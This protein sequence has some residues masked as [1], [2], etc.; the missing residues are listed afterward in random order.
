MKKKTLPSNDDVLMATRV[1]MEACHNRAWNAG[2]WHDPATGEEKERNMGELLAL[3][4]SELSEALEGHRKGLMDDKLTDRRMVPVEL[5]DAVIRIFDAVG[6]YYPEDYPA[7]LEKL[8][9]NDTRE[10]HK[11]ENRVK[12]GGKSY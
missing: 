12:V 8:I 9:Y 11:I 1:L 3:M 7:L 6:K 2:W 10:D 5:F 4:H